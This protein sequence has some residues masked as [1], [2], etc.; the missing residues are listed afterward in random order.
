MFSPH[1]IEKAATK[2]LAVRRYEKLDG[3][4]LTLE[5]SRCGL[6]NLCRE[7]TNSFASQAKTRWEKQTTIS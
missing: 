1:V 4:I 2:V 3:G 7:V 6:V 5:R